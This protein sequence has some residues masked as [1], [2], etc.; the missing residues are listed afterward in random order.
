MQSDTYNQPAPTFQSGGSYQDKP[1]KG[2]KVL[3]ILLILLLIAGA[4]A[5]GWWYGTD[6]ATKKAD[7]QISELEEQ[8]SDLNKKVQEL[9]ASAS[10]EEDDDFVVVKD[11][12]V[13]FEATDPTVKYEMSTANK[14]TLVLYTDSS[15]A[16]GV[17]CFPESDK[18]FGITVTRSATKLSAD[19]AET[20][21]FVKQI[22]N[23]YYYTS[24]PDGGCTVAA[25]RANL[26]TETAELEAIAKT[27]VAN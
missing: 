5:A 9:E 26:A 27:I 19:E 7:Q 1:K 14:N 12:N 10:K 20:L 15:K 17:K 11:W 22:G 18:T 21:T 23:N 3:L 25:E 4:A 16:I 13:K 8:V 6:Q 2:K 24:F